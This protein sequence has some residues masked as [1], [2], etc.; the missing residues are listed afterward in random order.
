M[1]LGIDN[2][3]P[4]NIR[5]VKANHWLGLHP[6]TPNV[7]GSCLW[8]PSGHHLDQKLHEEIWLR[9]TRGHYQTV[10]AT[11]GKQ[12]R[13]LYRLRLRTQQIGTTG[14]PAH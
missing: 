3:N 8:F 6:Q 4:L 14:T 1:N 13:T 10:G 5:Y 11:D 12:H 2:R 7:K 9:D